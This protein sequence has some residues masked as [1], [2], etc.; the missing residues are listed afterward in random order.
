MRSMFLLVLTLLICPL[1]Q[2]MS[3]AATPT[4]SVSDSHPHVEIDASATSVRI[5]ETIT[6]IGVPVNL[7]LPIYTLTLSSGATASVS[8]DNQQRGA[9][10]SD[11][12]F[13]IISAQGAMNQVTFVLRA[14]ATGTAEAQISATGEA[15]TEGGV[16]TWSG[17]GS[18]A[19]TLTVRP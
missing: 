2:W 13:E 19:L 7:G 6:I 17:G 3:A 16:Y 9:S 14:R 8:Y 12:E 11:A 1:A 15:R 5:G 10:T 4:P 18:D